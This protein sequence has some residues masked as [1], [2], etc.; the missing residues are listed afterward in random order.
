MARQQAVLEPLDL[1][2]LPA[3]I[4][5]RDPRLEQVKAT[6]EQTAAGVVIARTQSKQNCSSNFADRA[7]KRA[8]KDSTQGR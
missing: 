1:G 2:L 7:G 3:E 6:T 8:E 4:S 5:E